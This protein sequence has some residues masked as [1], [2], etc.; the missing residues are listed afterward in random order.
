MRLNPELQT[1]S[2]EIKT[3]TCAQERYQPV[4]LVCI[5][6]V[7]LSAQMHDLVIRHMP[8]WLAVNVKHSFRGL[9]M[10]YYFQ[11]HTCEKGKANRASSAVWWYFIGHLMKHILGHGALQF[12][13]VTWI[14]SL[15]LHQQ[16]CSLT[17]VTIDEPWY[18]HCSLG[19]NFLLGSAKWCDRY[20]C[21]QCA[22]VWLSW[23][24]AWLLFDGPAKIT[25][26]CSTAIFS[27]CAHLSI[28]SCYWLN[29]PVEQSIQG[30]CQSTQPVE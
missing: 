29:P 23:R 11:M 21:T 5:K 18:P 15:C 4:F 20:L 17:I 14:Q 26:L 12:N 30:C 3:L 7:D 2:F 25:C 19:L 8:P 16:F 24:R 22:S 28:F 27:C 10:K 6:N 13:N 1:W 9:K